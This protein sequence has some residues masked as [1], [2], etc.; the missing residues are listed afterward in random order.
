MT[1]G[2][3]FGSVVTSWVVTAL[4]RLLAATW[5]VRIEG[6]AEPLP[7]SIGAVWHENWL[8]GVWCFRDRGIAACVSRSRD[9]DRLDRVLRRLGYADSVRGSTSSG[10]T[11][12]LRGMVRTL[13]RGG[14][15]VLLT[16]GPRGPARRSQV[17]AVALAR[18]SGVPITPVAF[19]VRPRLR[20]R[21]WDR[22]VLPLPFAR[23]VCRLGAPIAVPRNADP[24]QEERIRSELDLA[25]ASL[26]G[27]VRAGLGRRG[28][29]RRPGGI[30]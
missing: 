17:G 30:V 15:V 9:G 28:L 13:A 12:A 25:L 22:S 11:A 6:A 4:L 20:A 29:L 23:I 8:P 24:D 27:V 14:S 3:S 7:V 19:A 10:G 18:L 16:D 5:R 26:D 2:H 21:S 1:R